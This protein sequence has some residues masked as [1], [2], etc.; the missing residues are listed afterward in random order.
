MNKSNLITW[1]ASLPDDAPEVEAVSAI[2]AGTAAPASTGRAL[3]ITEAANR[4]G[5]SRP[6]LYRAI[7]SATLRVFT[8]HPTARQRITEGELARWMGGRS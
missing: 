3:T 6:T 2:R 7:E 8:P 5:V 4:A 1:L